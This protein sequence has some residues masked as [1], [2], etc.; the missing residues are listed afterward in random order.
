MDNISWILTSFSA[1]AKLLFSLV[2]PFINLAANQRLKKKKKI[3][4]L[5]AEFLPRVDVALLIFQHGLH[6]DL[7]SAVC[8]PQTQGEK[9]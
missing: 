1:A 7:C 6:H 3:L 8:E 5:Q 2:S 9:R 4:T